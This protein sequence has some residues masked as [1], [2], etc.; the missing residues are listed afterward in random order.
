MDI[1]TRGRS[2]FRSSV[3]LQ[4]TFSLARN[5]FL[6]KGVPPFVTDFLNVSPHTVLEDSRS[7]PV[8]SSEICARAAQGYVFALIRSR[9]SAGRFRWSEDAGTVPVRCS[10]PLS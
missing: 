8:L 5:D 4:R 9:T 3:V 2:S 10:R 7:G 6:H 1:K